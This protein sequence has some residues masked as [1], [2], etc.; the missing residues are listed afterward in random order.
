MTA[1]VFVYVCPYVDLCAFICVCLRAYVIKTNKV[2]LKKVYHVEFYRSYIQKK[3]ASVK[4][5]EK[6]VFK[7]KLN[8]N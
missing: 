1:D 6:S 4:E 2:I 3:I 8:L 7:K 5:W